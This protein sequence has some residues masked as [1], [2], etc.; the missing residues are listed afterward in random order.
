MLRVKL[1]R[2]GIEVSKLG[3]GTGSAH[4]SGHCAQA[5]MGKRELADL[6]IYAFERGINFWDTAFQYGT[7]GHIREALKH[8]SRSKVVITSKLITSGRKDAEKDFHTSLKELGVDHLDVCLVHGVRTEKEFMRRRGT[9]DKLLEFKRQGKVRAVGISSHGLSALKAVQNVPEID[10]V[11][12]RINFAGLCVDS[13]RLGLYDQFA[14]IAWLKK[15]ARFVPK[16]LKS[17]I[18]PAAESGKASQRELREVEEILREIHS[19]T[20]GVIGMKVLA[21]GKS[22]NE[23]EKAINYVGSLSFVDSFIIGMLNKKEIE[24][25]CRAVKKLRVKI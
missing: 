12:A 18:R 24:E 6:L 2:T 25:N 14:S 9:L 8:V 13:C 16:K 3:M 5:L 10:L 23:A 7:H 15:S 20:V 17:I 1:G 11:L 4:P 21:E 22:G 19:L